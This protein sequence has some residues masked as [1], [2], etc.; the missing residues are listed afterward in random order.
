MQLPFELTTSLPLPSREAVKRWIDAPAR[1]RFIFGRT[2]VARQI[3]QHYRVAG[4]I[5]DFTDQNDFCGLPVMRSSDIP[6]ASP[7][8]SAVIGKP[9]SVKRVCERHRMDHV[10]F[11]AFQTACGEPELQL[12]FWRDS[13]A[14]LSA[15]GEAY[16]AL[17][18][19][20]ADD[21]SRQVL[22]SVLS[23]RL[24]GDLSV[25][26]GFSERQHEQ[27]FEPFLALS[28]HGES[29]LDI[30]GFDGATSME[31]AR[32][33]PGYETIH[34]F[35]PEPKNLRALEA[36]AASMERMQLHPVALGPEP[37]VLRFTSAD[38][39]SHVSDCGEH[40]VVQARLD[41]L[42]ISHGS[43][44]KMDI[45]GAELGAIAGSADFIRKHQPR[46]AIAA[47]HKVDDLWRIPSAIAPLMEADIYLRHYTEGLDETVMFFVPRTRNNACAS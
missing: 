27:Y 13:P 18:H 41:D 30:G 25:M 1:S 39:R 23:L 35:E 28:E 46:L 38:S 2:E 26:A 44:L 42:D 47:Y 34:V 21:A 4:V 16:S 7:V 37:D 24:S 36:L 45:E 8:L 40:T 32:R 9:A 12:R 33:C 10:D 17:W 11:F 6:A 43:F 15:H 5:D 3:L 20:L 19:A 29:F 14:D 31:F 22:R